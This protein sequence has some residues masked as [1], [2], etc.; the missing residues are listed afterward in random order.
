MSSPKAPQ[1]QV[2]PTPQAG[3]PLGEGTKPPWLQLAVGKT[4]RALLTVFRRG[5]I[6]EQLKY[7]RGACRQCGACCRLAFPCPFLNSKKLCVIYNLVRP[8]A[9]KCF[10]IDPRDLKDVGGTCGFHFVGATEA[11][12]D[13]Q[14]GRAPGRHPQQ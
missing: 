3:A 5:F 1:R 6:R 7:R 14:A 8:A 4:R 10:P 9:C 11:A 13:A 12:A 2:P